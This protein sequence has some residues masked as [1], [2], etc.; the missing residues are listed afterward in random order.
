MRSA[1]AL[2]VALMLAAMPVAAQDSAPPTPETA[3]GDLDEGL[4]LMERGMG[5]FL[6][7]L[8]D[9]MEPA[10]DE[11]GAAAEALSR[12]LGPMLADLMDLVDDV[13]AYHAPELLPNGDIIIRRRTPDEIEALPEGEIEI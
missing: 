8:M 7:G 4:S 3:P 11:M 13:R 2:F 1:P 9:E 5:L 12:N 6:R 10:L